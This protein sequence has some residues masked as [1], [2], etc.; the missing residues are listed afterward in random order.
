MIPCAKGDA[1]AMEA[2]EKKTT[3][4]LLSDWRRLTS[5]ELWDAEEA[6]GL[7]AY[8]ANALLINGKGSIDCLGRKKL[9]QYTTEAQR[10]VLGNNSHF[11]D[12]G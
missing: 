9:D 7:D 11:T 10:G 2:A 4:I 5:Q 8:C 3:P 12:I 6:S 1:E